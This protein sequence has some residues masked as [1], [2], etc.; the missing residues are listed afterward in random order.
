MTR[1]PLKG[2]ITPWFDDEDPY[3]DDGTCQDF[4]IDEDEFRI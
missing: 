4:L 1:N 2:L 3:E